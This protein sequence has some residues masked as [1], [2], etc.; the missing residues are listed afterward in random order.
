M[1]CNHYNR[2]HGM[3]KRINLP[4]QNKLTIFLAGTTLFLAGCNSSSG[5]NNSENDP[6]N[7]Q[8]PG[9]QTPT[10]QLRVITQD[11]KLSV[12]QF[13][14]RRMYWNDLGSWGTTMDDRDAYLL[15]TLAKL[16]SGYTTQQRDASQA[17]GDSLGA[18]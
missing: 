14:Y 16:H 10:E 6:G 2:N 3:T 9:G 17:D 4:S 13:V 5:G 11:N 12:A 15:A 8:N 1:I 7:G 18:S